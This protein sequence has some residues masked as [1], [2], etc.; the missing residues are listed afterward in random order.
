MFLAV[1]QANNEIKSK[2]FCSST[3]K[4]KQVLKDF[5]GVLAKQEVKEKILGVLKPYQSYKN[6]KPSEID[7]QSSALQ[8]GKLAQHP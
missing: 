7:T 1:E 2:V 6:S 5:D 3:D 4:G 8:N